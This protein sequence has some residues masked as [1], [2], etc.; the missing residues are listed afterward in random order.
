MDQGDSEKSADQAR[1]DPLTQELVYRLLASSKDPGDDLFG[2]LAPDERLG[3]S[4]QRSAQ[5]SMASIRCGTGANTTRPRRRSVSH[6]S[7]I[8]YVM[9][10][11]DIFRPEQWANFF[12]LVGTGAV[13]LTGLVFVAMSL[14]PKA[15][16]I[17]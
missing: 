7:L 16:A 12:L 10:A 8:N 17:D 14:N 11:A 4:S 1:A 6:N 2:L 3:S 5:I 13:T 9:I 15:I